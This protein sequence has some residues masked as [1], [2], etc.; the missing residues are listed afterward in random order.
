MIREDLLVYARGEGELDLLL[1]NCML[2]NVL[3]GTVHRA[4][5]A[6]KNGVI[7]G[8]EGFTKAKKVINLE[9]RYI[10]PGLIDSHVHLES[11]MVSVSQFARAVVPR[12][13]TTVVT[14]CHEIANVL[15]TRGIKYILSESR[16]VPL[17][18]FVMLPSC[19]PATN[20]ETSGAIIGVTE[21]EEMM[22]EPGVIGLGEVMNYPGV[23]NGLPDVLSKIALFEGK[24]VDGHAPGLRGRE[25]STYILAGP[26][27][28][29]E[30]TDPDEACEKIKK[31]MYVFLR[32]GTGA[33][34]L[35]D[36]VPAVLSGDPSRFC[37]C[38]DDRHPADLMERGHVDSI[39]RDAIALGISPVTA[40]QLATVNAAERFGLS[41]RGAIA[42][43]RIADIIVLDDLEAMEISMVFKAGTL[44]GAAYEPVF[45]VEA[46]SA[47]HESTFNVADIEKSKLDVFPKG[48]SA[49]VIRL[50][51]GQIMTDIELLPV[52]S[53]RKDLFYDTERDV[54]KV[55]VF[56]RHKGT[57]NVGVGLVRGFGLE[58]GALASSVAHDSHN[59]I[60]VGASDEDIL[61]AVRRVVE[62]KGG[63][64]VAVNG[65][66]V[67]ELPLPIAG[68]MSDMPVERVSEMQSACEKEAEAIGC[69]V[70]HPFMVMSFLAL[71]VIPRLRITDMGLVDVDA[72]SHVPLFL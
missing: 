15:G 23:I 20:L 37:L 61:C 35:A 19:V 54:L 2:V 56:E 65:S 14:D 40:I 57:G 44:V 45:D 64:V 68:L 7:V 27:S 62:L 66:C 58:R 13:T 70:E 10:A 41:D 3:S 30:C 52:E 31:G 53:S 9:G 38:T 11:S 22:H 48:S 16:L 17:D 24:P 12:G 36:L 59:I 50:V 49:R 47:I 18:V 72:F 33:R 60:A 5:V 21:L 28:D 67:A 25:L 42:P 34:N 43:G 69:A 71:P 63:Q 32:E 46:E 8:L 55:V 26:D 51:E 39:V 6:V 1:E 29:H 4:S